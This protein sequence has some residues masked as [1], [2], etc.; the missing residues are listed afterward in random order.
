MR[1]LPSSSHSIR[2]TGEAHLRRDMLEAVKARCKAA[3][4][5]EEF[6]NHTLGERA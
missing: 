1:T 2:P 4:L 6:C 3:G 5:S